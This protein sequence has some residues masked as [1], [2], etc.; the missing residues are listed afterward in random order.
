MLEKDS[1]HLERRRALLIGLALFLCYSYFYYIGGNW[2]VNSRQ[3]Q[4]ISLAED[5]RLAIDSYHRSTGDKAYYRGHYYSDKLIGPSLLAVPVYLLVRP[6]AALTTDSLGGTRLRAL[7]ITNVIANALPSALLGALLYLF[8][9][10][11]GLA[12]GLRAWLALAYGLGTLAFP[13]S[14][15]FFGH[16]LGAVC[17]A[18]AFMLLWKMRQAWTVRRALAAG[19]LLGLGAVC[20][21]TTLLMA[22]FLGLY[23]LW[24]ASGRGGERVSLGRTLARLA[25]LVVVAAIPVALQLAANWSS[26]GNPLV[27]PHVYHVQ[28]SFRA[29]H[30]S[31]LL[32]VH[33]PQLFPLYHL[34][35]GSWRGLFYGSPVLLL[36][37]PGLFLL[38]RT[39]RAE[40]VLI[41]AAWLGVLLMSAGYENWTSGTAYG[42]RYQIA[43]IP[44]LLIAL[45]PAAARW[46]FA[47]KALA[48]VSIAFTFV[49]TAYAPFYFPENL[50]DP[51]GTAIGS[52]S[53]GKL[54]QPNLG[55]ALGLSGLAS[56]LPLLAAEAGLVWG[57]AR[58]WP[59]RKQEGKPSRP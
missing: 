5:H 48:A 49:A 41:A 10:E 26:F 24:V 40:A 45:A 39:R 1:P 28:P 22:G 7:Q 11:L 14:T 38:G 30:T 12:S 43:A 15:A 23:A 18:G 32:G 29:R 59:R 8:L 44:L 25:P 52:F 47:F 50:R 46:P 51:L 37:L 21:F 9:A 56:L 36:A 13:Y 27:F 57:L 55:L 54:E 20:D 19:A 35:L 4:I 58:T 6:L 42:P 34:T 31:G 33:L 2:N 17:A 3:A 16:Q 53:R